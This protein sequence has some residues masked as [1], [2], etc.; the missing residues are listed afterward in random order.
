[1]SKKKKAEGERFKTAEELDIFVRGKIRAK[2][3]Q[4]LNAEYYACDYCGY[5]TSEWQRKCPKCGAPMEPA[6]W[7]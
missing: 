7:G 5:T 6:S 4:F 1:M 2:L 3:G